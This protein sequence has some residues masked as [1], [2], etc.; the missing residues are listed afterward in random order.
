MNKNKIITLRVNEKQESILLELCNNYKKNKSEM[1][2]FLIEKEFYFG[3]GNDD[4]E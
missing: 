1:I 2:L 3:G 4:N